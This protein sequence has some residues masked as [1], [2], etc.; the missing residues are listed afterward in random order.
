MSASA[1]T[2]LS[3]VQKHA[4]LLA[5]FFVDKLP[6][7]LLQLLIG[8]YLPECMPDWSP[9]AMTHGLVYALNELRRLMARHLA[10]KHEPALPPIGLPP[11]SPAAA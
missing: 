5:R 4:R 7:P 1:L 10:T 9:E 3:C 2:S 8:C 11:D 6:I